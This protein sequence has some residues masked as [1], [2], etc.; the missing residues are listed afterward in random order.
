MEP[1]RKSVGWMETLAKDDYRRLM[2]QLPEG[3]LKSLMREHMPKASDA[4]VDAVIE[5]IKSEV[6]ED[7]YALLQ[8]I[9]PGDAGASLSVHSACLYGRR[10]PLAAN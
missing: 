5:H 1:D 10:Q 4:Q 9:E 8:P 6:A 7:P 3:S 2:L